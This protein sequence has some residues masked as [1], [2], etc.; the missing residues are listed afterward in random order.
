MVV[1]TKDAIN[2]TSSKYPHRE[3]CIHKACI[4]KQ[5]YCCTSK[6]CNEVYCSVECRQHALWSSHALECAGFSTGKN[7]TNSFCL[8]VILG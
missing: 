7:S 3:L 2:I 8:H 1:G 5:A 6:N 4:A